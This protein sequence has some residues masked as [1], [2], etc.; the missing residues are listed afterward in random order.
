M[1]LNLSKDEIHALHVALSEVQDYFKKLK[2]HQKEHKKE[3]CLRC[4]DYERLRR[5][6]IKLCDCSTERRA[7]AQEKR[8]L[9]NI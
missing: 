1:K 6:L 9:K 5:K 4:K 2:K 7:T 8:I 3:T